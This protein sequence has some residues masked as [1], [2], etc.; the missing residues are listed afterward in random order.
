MI[1]VSYNFARFSLRRK[2]T[3]MKKIT[4]RLIIALSLVAGLVSCSNQGQKQTNNELDPDV[5]TNNK[6]GYK[7]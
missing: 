5:I 1:G 2:Y 4:G 3:K 7:I 6:R